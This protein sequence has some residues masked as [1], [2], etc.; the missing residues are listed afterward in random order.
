MPLISRA[1]PPEAVTPSSRPDVYRDGWID[2]NKNG[3]L[4]L[5]EDTSAPTERRVEDLLALMTVNEKTCQLATLYG[6]KRVLKDDLPTESW[7]N[8]VWADGIANID[9]HLNGI[10]G[11]RGKPESPYTSPPSQHARAI[12]EVQRW[13]IE[14]T[15][16]GVPVDMTNEG[17]RGLCY[18]SATNFPAQIGIGA[19]W[20][21]ELAREVGRVTGREAKALGYTNIYSPILDL[22]RDPRWG[23]CRRVLWRGPIPRHSDGRRAGVGAA[24]RGRRLDRQALCGLQRSERGPRRRG[25][26]R[27]ARHV[28]RGARPAPG[29]VRRGH[30]RRRT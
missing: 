9:E 7:R 8:E 16:L 3:Q 18:A 15:R 4:D 27:P 17:I 14:E 11:W 20:N 5:Y 21:P 28:A 10:P 6:Y 29:A 23:T 26:H 1:T 24:R 19:T 13:F 12:N 22:A 30:P 2:F 25:P